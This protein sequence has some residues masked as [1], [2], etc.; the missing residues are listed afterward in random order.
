[1]PQNPSYDLFLHSKVSFNERVSERKTSLSWL[2]PIINLPHAVRIDNATT[3]ALTSL[4]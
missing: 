3:K 4:A 2:K 1:M